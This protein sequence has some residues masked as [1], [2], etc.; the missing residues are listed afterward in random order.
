MKGV[1]RHGAKKN[2][3]PPD[4]DRCPVYRLQSE[5][6]TRF[7]FASEGSVGAIVGVFLVSPLWSKA[8]LAARA[9]AA[10]A[11]S[12]VDIQ[13]WAVA[14]W[15]SSAASRP[16]HYF[17]HCKTVPVVEHEVWSNA[18]TAKDPGGPSV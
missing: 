9:F 3:K 17:L 4:K 5:F 14:A 11:T 16:T 1:P 2:T 10:T 18:A 15:I 6:C 13:V 8:P 12:H 7:R